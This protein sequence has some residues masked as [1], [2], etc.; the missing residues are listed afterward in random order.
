MQASVVIFILGAVMFLH[1][2]QITCQ[3]HDAA[4]TVRLFL[5]FLSSSFL[6]VKFIYL[7]FCASGTLLFLSPVMLMPYQVIIH[8][9]IT[10]AAAEKV[11]KYNRFVLYSLNE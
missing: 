5:G 4:G 1:F 11:E 3:S 10:A 2:A 9:K 7:F 6:A 8:L